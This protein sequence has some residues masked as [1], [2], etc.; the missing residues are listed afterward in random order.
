M[1]NA[2]TTKLMAAQILSG[3]AAA[4]PNYKSRTDAASLANIELSAR[5]AVTLSDCV[6]TESKK[7]KDK[8]RE[9]RQ[10]EERKRKNKKRNDDDDNTPPPAQKESTSLH[11][12]RGT[13]MV[14]SGYGMLEI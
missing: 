5:I 13:V 9:E 10:R 11:G 4:T 8:K 3:I 14:A 6:D 7:A 2:Q 1:D 12:G